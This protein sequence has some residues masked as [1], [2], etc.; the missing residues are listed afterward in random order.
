MNEP[1]INRYKE[2]LANR[3]KKLVKFFTLKPDTIIDDISLVNWKGRPIKFKIGYK[4]SSFPK[5]KNEG[6]LYEMVKQHYVQLYIYKDS[7]PINSYPYSGSNIQPDIKVYLYSKDDQYLV[8]NIENS[9][10]VVHGF[11]FT[12]N[13]IAGRSS[14]KIISVD[15][16]DNSNIFVNFSYPTYSG[17]PFIKP[18]LFGLQ[19]ITCDFSSGENSSLIVSGFKEFIQTSKSE[20]VFMVKLQFNDRKWPN[21]K[22]NYR[23]NAK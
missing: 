23:L 20:N 5:F 15:D 4:S 18:V 2:S 17:M 22:N 21:H 13:F 9:D 6:T 11:L 8:F 7:I 12:D 1:S 19:S 16:L 10:L 14:D 3:I